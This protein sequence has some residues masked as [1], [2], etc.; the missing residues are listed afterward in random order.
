MYLSTLFFFA[1]GISSAYAY[2]GC[3]SLL[4]DGSLRLTYPSPNSQGAVHVERT[5]LTIPVS[6]LET[7]FPL[8]TINEQEGYPKLSFL[9][10]MEPL[11]VVGDQELA[12]K[13]SYDDDNGLWIAHNPRGERY[14][15]FFD[16]I[17][18]FSHACQDEWFHITDQGKLAFGSFG[19]NDQLLLVHQ[20]SYAL[21]NPSKA[22][23]KKYIRISIENAGEIGSA[24]RVKF[25]YETLARSS[26]FYLG[27][28]GPAF[29]VSNKEVRLAPN[30]EIS[31]EDYNDGADS[32]ADVVQD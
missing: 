2:S 30:A 32:S 9:Y 15:L 19:E 31:D 28:N 8:M 11:V 14:Y 25:K 26:M 6:S 13:F 20:K 17:G 7:T 1:L 23:D 5:T 22:D 3:L 29:S 27:D 10:Q 21:F 4:Q 12:T 18:T 16:D 24:D